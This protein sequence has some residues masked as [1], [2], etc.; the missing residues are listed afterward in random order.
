MTIQFREGTYGATIVGNYFPKPT[1]YGQSYAISIHPDSAPD[2]IV[3]TV[4][5]PLMNE[6]GK[7]ATS[8]DGDDLCNKSLEIL[9]HLGFAGGE[10]MIARLDPEHPQFHSFKGR[11]CVAWCNGDTAKE[12]WRINIP[13]EHTPPDAKML[14][15]LQTLCGSSLREM[16]PGE[17]VP[18]SETAPAATPK[19][20]PFSE[21]AAT[22]S[23]PESRPNDDIPF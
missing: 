9:A 21:P 4:F 15:K 17:E 18:I 3:R 7:R 10:A 2:D 5:L 23:A 8:K 13:R 11:R 6:N 19:A 14:E 16:T 1:Q 20:D 22:E 12:K